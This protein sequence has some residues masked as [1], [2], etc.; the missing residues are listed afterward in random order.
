MLG[1]VFAIVLELR[2]TYLPSRATRRLAK[3]QQAMEAPSSKR[4]EERLL[5]GSKHFLRRILISFSEATYGRRSG[6]EPTAGH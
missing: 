1:F 5:P 3:L 6:G 4:G 2:T